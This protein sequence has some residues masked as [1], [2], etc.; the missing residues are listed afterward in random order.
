MII[1][2]KN[3]DLGDARLDLA[4]ALVLFTH[5][6]KGKIAIQTIPS[7]WV[8]GICCVIAAW[9]GWKNKGSNIATGAVVAS[10][11]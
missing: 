7:M 1:S 3:K 10:N 8:A 6:D 9:L 11:T 5:D 2:S 4:K